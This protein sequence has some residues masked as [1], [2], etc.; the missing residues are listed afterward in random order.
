MKVFT[1]IAILFCFA[2][3]LSKEQ[4]NFKVSY[5]HSKIKAGKKCSE[6]ISY[7]LNRCRKYNSSLNALISY[8]PQ[9]KADASKL[10]SFYA[11][12]KT[13]IGKLHCIPVIVKD[14]ID[15]AGLPNTGGI[16]ALSNSIPKQDATIVK[17]LKNHGAIIIAKSNLAELA[18]GN[19]TS[20][21]GGQCHNPF[22]FKKSCGASSTGSGASIGAGLA[23]ISV[24]T[25]TDGSIMI[26]GAFNG[27]YGL[28]TRSQQPSIDGIIPLFER[29]DTVGPFTKYIDDLVLAYSIMSNNS[30]VYSA[31][32]RKDNEK[33]SSLRVTLLENF[34]ES[35]SLPGLNYYVDP[36]IKSIMTDTKK[37]MKSIK[38]NVTSLAFNQAELTNIGSVMVPL[39]NGSP[40]CL[41]ACTKKSYNS[42][43]N[44]TSRFYPN[45]TCKSF[46]D[47]LR[48]P[49]LS[50]YWREELN[51]SVTD[52]P[53]LEC[54]KTCSTYDEYKVKFIDI[55]N[56]WFVRNNADALVI[57]SS[58][59]LPYDCGVKQKNMTT[60]L[61]LASLS[62]KLAFNVPVGYSK[63]TFESPAG[64]PVG[65]LV[66][67][68][69]D[70]IV[71]SFKI[72]KLLENSKN[73]AKLPKSTPLI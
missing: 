3:D 12:N 11:K 68:R 62:N 17:R 46:D 26:P 25:D 54:N 37:R 39:Q 21:T 60:F 55:V 38:L 47:L 59:V 69:D 35:F 64:L 7:F 19:E 28:R 36:E 27:V 65:L 51:K 10:D 20:E 71:Q 13:L 49:S 70:R 24:G 41:I 58:V 45:A 5:I 52:N 1:L 42:Y 57:P 63:P 16:K 73:F 9:A 66:I 56:S 33:P 48:N 15:I 18:H 53:D 30:T 14:N 8:N 34:F 43:F 44:N 67:S 32:I 31:F 4:D 23:V 2:I 29:Q 6:I 72:A 40:P 50:H 22:N 61:I